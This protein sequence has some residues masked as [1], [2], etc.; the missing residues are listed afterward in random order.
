MTAGSEIAGPLPTRPAD[1]FTAVYKFFTSDDVLLYVGICDEPIKRWYTHARKSWWPKVDRFSVV[2]HPSRE[3]AAEAERRA[4]VAEKPIHNVAMNGIAYHGSMFP[5][6]HLHR[7][8]RERFGD[9]PFSMAD[10]E[11]VLGISK[12]SASSK[13]R[14]LCQQGLFES[15]GKLRGPAGRA[16]PHYRAVPLESGKE[17]PQT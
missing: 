3:T 13:A 16:V 4:I 1:G 12:G 7:L 8:T 11:A 9:R 6:V 17:A 15:L 2:W 5:R 14:Q 10:L